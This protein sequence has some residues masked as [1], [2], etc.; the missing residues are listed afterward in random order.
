MEIT[1][2]KSKLSGFLIDN[3]QKLRVPKWFSEEGLSDVQRVIFKTLAD[4]CLRVD[5]Y[6]IP[7]SRAA[8]MIENNGVPWSD[9][10]SLCFIDLAEKGYISMVIMPGREVE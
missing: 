1:I 5:E 10:V 8:R 3:D 7:A 9:S 4:Y 6:T 2:N